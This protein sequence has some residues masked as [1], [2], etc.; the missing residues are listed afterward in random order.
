MT[1]A[2]S[3]ESLYDEKFYD[4]HY[5][6]ALVSARAIIPILFELVKPS[7]VVDFG[8]GLGTW[9]RVCQENGVQTVLGLEGPH[10]GLS[11]LLISGDS[12]RQTNFLEKVT[13]PGTFGLAICLEVVE[14]L[15]NRAGIALVQT[16]TETAPLI[17]FSAAIPGQGGTHHINERWA[18]YWREVFA[19]HGFQR[20]DPIRRRVWTDK[21]IKWWYRQNIFLYATQEAI[22]Q[23]EALRNEMAAAKGQ[24]VELVYRPILERDLS[25]RGVLRDLRR[26]TF[27]AIRRRLGRVD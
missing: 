17:L 24:D 4:D 18:S 6:G 9:L 19:H 16:L 7:S 3:L 10:V 12:F 13:S 11:K 5:D 1:T 22:E 20:L 15:P 27:H 23:S 25:V 21:Q 26:A 2:S 14:H 8:C